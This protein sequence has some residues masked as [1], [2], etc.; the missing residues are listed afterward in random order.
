MIV[1]LDI[2][3]SILPFAFAIHNLEEAISMENWTKSIPS[4]VHPKVTTAQFSIAVGLFTVLGFLITLARNYYPSNEIYLLFVSGFAGMLFLNTFFPHL[5][6]TIYLK[7][8]APGVITGVLIN[9]PLT[10]LI[11]WLVYKLQIIS[12]LQLGLSI[13]IGGLTGAILAFLFLKIGRQITS[14]KWK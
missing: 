5:L 8:Y 7:K 13:L 14:I 4:K 2:L 10:I 3:I 9:L 6:A 12:N 1:N 11:L